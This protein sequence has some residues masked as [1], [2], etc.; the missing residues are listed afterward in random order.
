MGK[1]S[2]GDRKSYKKTFFMIIAKDKT[3]IEATDLEIECFGLDYER[4]ALAKT[5]QRLV[6][7]YKISDVLEIPAG[8]ERAMPSIYSLGFGFA[9]CKVTLVNGV[10][11]SLRVWKEL[12]VDGFMRNHL[13]SDILNTGLENDKYDFVWNFA[14]FST[15]RNHDEMLREM[16][17]LSRKFI[18]IFSPNAYNPGYFSHHI[19]HFIARVPWTHGD[20]RFFSPR[21]TKAFLRGHGLKIVKVG[22]LDCPPWPDSIGFRDI[23]LHRLKRDLSKLN[24]YPRYVDYLHK[25]RF[26]AWI[27]ALNILENIP[28]PLFMKFFYSHIFY[29][30]ALKEK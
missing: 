1:I 20:T 10:E 12:G 27:Y 17:R 29:V 24:W 3:K 11:T 18:A 13:C 21:K 19:A 16:V 4:Y 5:L 15:F 2:E 9:G 28:I 6:R 7:K 25:G 14:S 23:R 8:G 26:P 22:V 30:I